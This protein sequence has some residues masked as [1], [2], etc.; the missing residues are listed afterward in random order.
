MIVVAL[1]SAYFDDKIKVTN[2]SKTMTIT[3]AYQ[4]CHSCMHK[5][6]QSKRKRAKITLAVFALDLMW[7]CKFHINVQDS[8]KPI[9]FVS[10]SLFSVLQYN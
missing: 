8:I 3:I 2:L 1:I 4:L 10:T 6:K 5:E 7:S 9:T